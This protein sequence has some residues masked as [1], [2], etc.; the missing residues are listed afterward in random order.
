MGWAVPAA[1]AANLASCLQG[2]QLQRRLP[3]G[4]GHLPAMPGEGR[5]SHLQA[6]CAVQPAPAAQPLPPPGSA[7][8]LPVS[9]PA[10]VQCA[11]ARVPQPPALPHPPAG[12]G[13]LGA[14]P[15]VPRAL[16][17][18]PA[19]QARLWAVAQGRPDPHDGSCTVQEGAERLTPFAAAF[20]QHNHSGRCVPR[21]GQT[22][23]AAGL[24]GRADPLVRHTGS[25]PHACT[26]AMIRSAKC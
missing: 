17:P 4:T 23:A 1:D 12:H 11:P 13:R 16:P 8:S 5:R 2:W 14:A 7:Q 20:R 15:A 25:N 19:P 21:L 26:A 9:P 24:P 3:A 18:P 22:E 6:P 10:G